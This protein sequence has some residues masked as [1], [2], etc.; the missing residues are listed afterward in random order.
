M[1]KLV[2]EGRCTV[3]YGFDVKGNEVHLREKPF[4]CAG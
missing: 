4:E 2:A 3:L 1:R